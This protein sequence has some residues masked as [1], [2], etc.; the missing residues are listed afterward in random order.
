MISRKDA[1]TVK[2]VEEGG[3]LSMASGK[4][5]VGRGVAA[6]VVAGLVCF[7]LTGATIYLVAGP[8]E[9]WEFLAGIAALPALPLAL[10]Q[11]G[12]R[13]TSFAL[14]LLLFGAGTVLRGPDNPLILIPFV[15]LCVSAAAVVTE[16]VLRG[17]DF[18]VGSGS[19]RDN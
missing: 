18:L 7:A 15:G 10:A 5:E 11:R 8:Y 3:R 19:W 16:V 17:L 4:S 14:G 12:A 9:G 13:L 2:G 6:G 1:K